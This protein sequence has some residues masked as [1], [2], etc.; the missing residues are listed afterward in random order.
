[1]SP[2]PETIKRFPKHA[3]RVRRAA[4]SGQIEQFAAPQ[5]R[6][7]CCCPEPRRNGLVA[8]S[9]RRPRRGPLLPDHDP[10]PE[11]SPCST[12]CYQRRTG[13]ARPNSSPGGSSRAIAR[14]TTRPTPWWRPAVFSAAKTWW[15]GTGR[16]RFGLAT[17]RSRIAPTLGD[18]RRPAGGPTANVASRGAGD[19]SLSNL[20][21]YAILAAKIEGR[22]RTN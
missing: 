9:P 8:A 3:D 16:R 15:C 18:W 6:G 13:C 5:A 11:A 10:V 22:R 4:A 19:L 21:R 17:A 1:V 2:H 14:S 12:T 20:Y 7:E